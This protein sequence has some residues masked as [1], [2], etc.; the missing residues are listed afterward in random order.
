MAPVSEDLPMSVLSGIVRFWHRIERWRNNWIREAIEFREHVSGPGHGLRLSDLFKVAAEDL[1]HQ[2][3]LQVH[4]A[5]ELYEMGKHALNEE[6]LASLR[7]FIILLDNVWLRNFSKGISVG[8]TVSRWHPITGLF[9]LNMDQ[10]KPRTETMPNHEFDHIDTIKLPRI[11]VLKKC[12][13]DVLSRIWRR[14]DRYIYSFH[15]WRVEP[16]KNN[17]DG[18]VNELGIYSRVIMDEAKADEYSD[19][20]KVFGLPGWSLIPA[21]SISAGVITSYATSEPTLAG[22]ASLLPVLSLRPILKGYGKSRKVTD[23]K[24]E[25]NNGL[26][27]GDR[28]RQYTRT[29]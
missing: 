27:I 22:L 5:L 13:G 25:F 28:A 23:I 11:E 14:S 9:E 3:S 26:A 1:F 21:M 18:L 29:F 19:E 10:D 20:Y 6:E 16:S 24:V 8:Y 7:A 17:L 15:K 4:S 12:S 2:N